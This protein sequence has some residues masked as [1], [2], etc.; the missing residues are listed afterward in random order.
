MCLSSSAVPSPL[1][2]V[3]ALEEVLVAGSSFSLSCSITPF[4]VDTPTTVMSSWTTPNIS[5]VQNPLDDTS[6]VLN[7]A[8]ASTAD[9]G[10]YTCVST[11]SL[12]DSTSSV[13]IMN[14]EPGNNSTTIVVSKYFSY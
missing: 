12:I 5:P 4:L 9:S 3:H 8:N 10:V 14:S 2:V 6:V 7:I 1:V 11:V 13:Y